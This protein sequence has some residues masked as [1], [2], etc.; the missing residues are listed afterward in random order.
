MKVSWIPFSFTAKE[1][2][3][4]S[5]GLPEIF[6]MTARTRTQNYFAVD[7]TSDSVRLFYFPPFS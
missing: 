6:V 7:V 4:F 5:F 3:I 1:L 2:Y